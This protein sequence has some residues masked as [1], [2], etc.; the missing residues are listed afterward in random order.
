MAV[1]SRFLYSLFTSTPSG[2]QPQARAPTV[3]K[4]LSTTP[5]V[6]TMT[7][8][9]KAVAS[10]AGL[11]AASFA[12]RGIKVGITTPVPLATAPMRPPRRIMMGWAV[13][14]V[15]TFASIEVR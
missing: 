13:A 10:R 1:R 14:G 7:P 3:E 11:E 4:G 2:A 5:L 12:A 8:S 15:M 9:I 6:P